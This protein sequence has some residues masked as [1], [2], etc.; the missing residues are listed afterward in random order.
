MMSSDPWSIAGYVLEML[1]VVNASGVD[2]EQYYFWL[3]ADEL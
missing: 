1:R 3:G 2:A